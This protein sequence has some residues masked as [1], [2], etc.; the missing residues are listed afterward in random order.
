ML[1]FKGVALP[2]WLIDTGVIT[3][4]ITVLGG[5]TGTLVTALVQRRDKITKDQ[6]DKIGDTLT[7]IQRQLELV[8]ETTTDIKSTADQTKEGTLKI[9]RYRLFH[10]LQKYIE[11]GGVTLEEYREL[12]I[13]FDSYVALGGNG[14]IQK[15]FHKFQ[16]LPIINEK[17]KNN[18]E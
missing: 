18:H 8:D 16:E 15:L 1:I 4:L 2:P 3:T 11:E 7:S 5:I 12:S 10:D 9:Q 14:E 17:G 13:L 6:Y